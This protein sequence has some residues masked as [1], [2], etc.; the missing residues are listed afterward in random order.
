MVIMKKFSTS[1]FI[2]FL[3][4]PSINLAQSG[5]KVVKIIPGYVLIDTDTGIGK[6]NDKIKIQRMTDEGIIEVGTVQIIKFRDGKTAAKIVKERRKFKINVG[7]VTESYD[8]EYYKAIRNLFNPTFIEK[9]NYLNKITVK[10]YHESLNSSENNLSNNKSEFG[11]GF[12]PG[13]FVPNGDLKDAYDNAFYFG[14]LLELRSPNMKN[15]SILLNFYYSSLSVRSSIKYVFDLYDGDMDASI[16][17]ANLSFRQITSDWFFLDI[18]CGLYNPTI[19]I[20]F[21]DNK[22]KIKDT[23]FGICVGIGACSYYSSSSEFGASLD[24]KYHTYNAKNDWLSFFT[25]NFTIFS[26]LSSEFT[27]RSELDGIAPL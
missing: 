12:C 4:Y 14:A 24:I 7:D 5:G 9:E 26:W 21:Y 16:F 2:L 18:G 19:S 15:S 20:S 23:F 3:I 27:P 13:I 17:M 8:F 11:L 25:F 22:E 6:I 1:L 10:D